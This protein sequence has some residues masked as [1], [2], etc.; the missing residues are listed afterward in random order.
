MLCGA[1][2]CEICPLIYL[3]QCFPPPTLSTRDIC[4][5]ACRLRYHVEP[6]RCS[7]R[8]LRLTASDVGTGAGSCL[9]TFQSRGCTIKI[10]V[11]IQSSR[12]LQALHRT[13]RRPNR[14]A[15]GGHLPQQVGETR[16]YPA[17][18]SCHSSACQHHRRDKMIDAVPSPVSGFN[19][20]KQ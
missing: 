10:S 3:K 2:T 19:P 6:R 20:S 9:S 12:V 11:K 18:S 5:S 15:V 13:S 4:V 16:R 1:G 17:G 14:P 8:R 7:W